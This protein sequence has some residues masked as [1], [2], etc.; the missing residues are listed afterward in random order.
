M[1]TYS[2]LDIVYEKCFTFFLNFT[3]IPKGFTRIGWLWYKFCFNNI[4][5]ILAQRK[6]FYML[7]KY[8]F[9]T[10]FF[11]VK[12]IIFSEHSLKTRQEHK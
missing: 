12:R 10:L 1:Q 3:T 4:S 7:E 11:S 5:C 6:Y 8:M 2:H 9:E